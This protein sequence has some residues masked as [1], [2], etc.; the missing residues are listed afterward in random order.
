MNTDLKAGAVLAALLL[1][2]AVAL[3]LTAGGDD[4]PA[5]RGRM[6]VERS[7]SPTGLGEVQVTVTGDAAAP[8]GAKEVTLT[9]VDV[10]D[11]PVTTARHPWPLQ[12]D[13]VEPQPHLHQAA[14]PSELD[15]IERCRLDTRPPLTAILPLR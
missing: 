10:R 8:A 7:V 4:E 11:E 5:G 3:T 14:A 13:E 6:T 9:C 15:R 12:K 2:A 1:V